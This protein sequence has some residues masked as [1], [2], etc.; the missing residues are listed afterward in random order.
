M[1]KNPRLERKYQAIKKRKGSNTAK[2]AVARDI[3]KIIYHILK[4]KR[5]YYPEC[6]IS[7]RRTTQSQSAGASALA[8]V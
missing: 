1:R 6:L 3:L 8:R 7:K 2:V 4:E 5:P